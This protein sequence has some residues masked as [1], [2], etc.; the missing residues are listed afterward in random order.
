MK[1]KILVNL[2]INSAIKTDLFVIYFYTNQGALSSCKSRVLWCHFLNPRSVTGRL[3]QP[4]KLEM[5]SYSALLTGFVRK[6]KVRE[7]QGILDGKGKS[8]K[9][10]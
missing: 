4:F 1:N 10:Q 9:S 2:R 8:V 7:S 6:M 5:T 3:D